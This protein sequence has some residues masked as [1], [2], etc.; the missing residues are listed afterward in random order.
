MLF[1]FHNSQICIILTYKSFVFTYSGK[2]ALA[3]VLMKS[4]PEKPQS[5]SLSARESSYVIHDFVFIKTCLLIA[6][7]ID[8]F[9]I[10]TLITEYRFDCCI[11]PILDSLMKLLSFFYFFCISYRHFSLKATPAHRDLRHRYGFHVV[12]WGL[13]PRYSSPKW[14]S[15]S[16]K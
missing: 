10:M 15:S 7:D 13:R 9:A 5:W 16:H 6:C 14:L 2:L 11:T 8:I 4:C 1:H 12:R 3:S